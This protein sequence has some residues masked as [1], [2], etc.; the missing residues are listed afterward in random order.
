VLSVAARGFGGFI[1][2][3]LAAGPAVTKPAARLLVN[4]QLDPV[5]VEALLAKGDESALIDKLLKQFKTPKDALEKSRL[6]MLAW[7]VASGWLDV[8]VALM[9]HTRGIAHAKFGLI[10]DPAGDSLAFSGSGNET[11]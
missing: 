4:E 6:Q 8:R 11:G 9:R 10:T 1:Q 7:L 5:D 2:N 3:L